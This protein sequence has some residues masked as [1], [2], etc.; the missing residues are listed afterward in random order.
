MDAVTEYRKNM[1]FVS[2]TFNC[3]HCK[4]L[5]R[6]PKEDIRKTLR[7]YDLTQCPVCGGEIRLVRGGTRSG[8]A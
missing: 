8:Q 3:P 7:N 2:V 1:E 4:L 6:V 5:V